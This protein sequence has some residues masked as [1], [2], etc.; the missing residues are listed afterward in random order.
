[1]RWRLNSEVGAQPSCAPHLNYCF[2]YVYQVVHGTSSSAVPF[3]TLYFSC[4]FI[5]VLK[6]LEWKAFKR[7]GFSLMIE[8]TFCHVTVTNKFSIKAGHRKTRDMSGRQC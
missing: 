7:L 2:A 8:E 3:L 6:Q 4:Y 1:M 5:S